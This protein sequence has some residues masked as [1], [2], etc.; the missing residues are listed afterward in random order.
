VIVTV[1]SEISVFTGFS[2]TS[3]GGC[4]VSVFDCSDFVPGTGAGAGISEASGS[5]G[6]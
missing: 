5:V 3:F 6:G 2:S 1:G 4:F